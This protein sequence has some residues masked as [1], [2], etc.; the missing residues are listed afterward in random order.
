MSLL[1]NLSLILLAAE[2]F[3]FALVPLA[4]LGGLVYGLWWLQR[5]ENLPRWLGLARSY[6]E[7][8]R[9]YVELAMEAAVKPILLLH[10]AVA[11]I[12]N[13]LDAITGFVKEMR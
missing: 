2:A 10:S 13:W 9:A 12:Q 6:L 8:G 7:M 5:H 3:I 4:L 1:S 11:T